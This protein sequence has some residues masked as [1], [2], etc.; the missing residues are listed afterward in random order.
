MDSPNVTLAG[1]DAILVFMTASSREEAEAIARCLVGDR[2]AACVNI[3]P[4]VRSIFRWEDKL[5]EED[6]IFLVAKST[7][8]RFQGLVQKVHE[9]HSYQVP[10]II[11]IPVVEGAANYLRWIS[12]MTS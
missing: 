1:G 4:G 8:G 3:L 12:E 7:R 2:L 10:E 9:L 5:S 11:A 6:E